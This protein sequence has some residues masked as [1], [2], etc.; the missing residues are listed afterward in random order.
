MGT[1]S[2]LQAKKNTHGNLMVRSGHPPKWAAFGKG[3]VAFSDEK[4]RE[5][6]TKT[7]ITIPQ[8]LLRCS[9]GLLHTCSLSRNSNRANNDDKRG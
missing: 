3:T 5:K 1:I 7:Q 2:K 6:R 4:T 8:N 9:K